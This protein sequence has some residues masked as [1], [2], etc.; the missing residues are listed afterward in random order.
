MKPEIIT[1][2][3]KIALHMV[4]EDTLF[5]EIYSS[6]PTDKEAIFLEQCIL[7]DRKKC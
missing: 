5:K 7:K 1:L 3:R 4:N 2:G 6:R